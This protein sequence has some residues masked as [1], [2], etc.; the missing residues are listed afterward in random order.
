[1]RSPHLPAMLSPRLPATQVVLCATVGTWGRDASD[2][3]ETA[4][5]ELRS[6]QCA[7]L[8]TRRRAHPQRPPRPAPRRAACVSCDETSF[9]QESPHAM[10]YFATVDGP[11]GEIEASSLDRSGSDP[12]RREMCCHLPGHPRRQHLSSPI[13]TARPRTDGRRRST[14]LRKNAIIKR[15][16][17]GA[18]A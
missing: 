18:P 17:T 16:R 10:A 11:G 4:G 14:R 2:I 8:S 5:A 9:C 15:A 13:A 7:D 1:M 6:S 12:R 3:M